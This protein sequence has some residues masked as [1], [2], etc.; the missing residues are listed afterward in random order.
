MFSSGNG[1]SDIDDGVFTTTGS[2]G[3]NLVANMKKVSSRNATSHIAVMSMWVLLRGNFAFGIV[4]ILL[5]L[6]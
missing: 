3:L 6:N 4:I 5:L 2:S 1:N